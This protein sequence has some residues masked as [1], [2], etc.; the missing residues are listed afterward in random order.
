MWRTTVAA[1][2]LLPII[3]PTRPGDSVAPPFTPQARSGIVQTAKK[4]VARE[5]EVCVCCCE[6]LREIGVGRCNHAVACGLCNLRL[7]LLLNDTS[8]IV[9]KQ[10][11]DR[12]I[13]ASHHSPRF[14]ELLNGF[15]NGS[16]SLVLDASAGVLFEDPDFFQS[17]RRLRGFACA[18]CQQPQPSQ[19]HL[20]L[21]VRTRHNLTF[22]DICLVHRKVFL[23]EQVWRRA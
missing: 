8:C 18:V 17:M 16:I 6:P 7:R 11:V 5:D 19:K 12:L 23:Q 21:H 13:I 2:L 4:P 14:Q 22:C 10:P 15:E 9:C 3:F 20:L 1:I